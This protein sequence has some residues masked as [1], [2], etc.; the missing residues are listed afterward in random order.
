MGGGR[1]DLAVWAGLVVVTTVEGGR[2]VDHLSVLAG[3]LTDTIFANDLRV[4]KRS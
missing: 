4:G 2:N 3:E 1:L